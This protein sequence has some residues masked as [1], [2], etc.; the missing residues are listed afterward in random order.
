[1]HCDAI[2]MK[3][4]ASTSI[5][6]EISR[7]GGRTSQTFIF[8]ASKQWHVPDAGFSRGTDYTPGSFLQGRGQP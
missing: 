2:G 3:L 1:M 5:R 8:R 6:G 7:T 4:L